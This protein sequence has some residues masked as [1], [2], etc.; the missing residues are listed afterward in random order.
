MFSPGDFVKLR[1]NN[2]KVLLTNVR[3]YK[4][5]GQYYSNIDYWDN[6]SRRIERLSFVTDKNVVKKLKLFM[7]KM[8]YDVF[9]D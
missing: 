4:K 2:K 5:G 8:N 6:R 3:T 9:G 7:E 1:S